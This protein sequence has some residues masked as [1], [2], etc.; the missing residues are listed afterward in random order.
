MIQNLSL[1]L[2]IMI[3]PQTLVPKKATYSKL[4]KLCRLLTGG[5]QI[6]RFMVYG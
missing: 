6:Q 4:E 1:L 5:K 2:V 3:V